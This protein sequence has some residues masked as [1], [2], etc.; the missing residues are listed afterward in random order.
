M[1]TEANTALNLALQRQGDKPVVLNFD[2]DVRNLFSLVQH[3]SRFC[4][5]PGPG[6][7]I[8]QRITHALWQMLGKID[9]AFCPALVAMHRA[10]AQEP[11]RS[12]CYP[13]T[14]NPQPS[15]AK[16]VFTTDYDSLG[17]AIDIL[18]GLD[19][20]RLEHL[21]KSAE[22]ALADAVR[23]NTG[24]LAMREWLQEQLRRLLLLRG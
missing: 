20:D 14:L 10:A 17:A 1:S 7:G 11:A 5:Q 9:P 4:D 16:L 18:R 23:T 3:L 15:T 21:I 6:R 19:R 24:G 2:L 8:T 12:A 22:G 13:S